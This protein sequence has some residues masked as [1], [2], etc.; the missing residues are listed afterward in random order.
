[1]ELIR[2]P[3]GSGWCLACCLAML[4]DHGL[5]QV[6]NAL[7]TKKGAIRENH[8]TEYGALWYMLEHGFRLGGM[9][10]LCLDGSDLAEMGDVAFDVQAMLQNDAIVSVKLNSLPTGLYHAV[11]WNAAER[12]IYDPAVGKMDLKDYSVVYWETVDRLCTNYQKIP[13]NAT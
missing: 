1:M 13:P 4:T 7:S 8:V 12:T 3:D 9:I 11:V 2:Q 10:H 6:L 5:E